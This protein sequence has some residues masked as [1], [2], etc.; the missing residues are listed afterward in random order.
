MKWFNN[1]YRPMPSPAIGFG[2]EPVDTSIPLIYGWAIH[3][4]LAEYYRSGF[5]DGFDTGI[6][7]I[8]Q[9]SKKLIAALES[10]RAENPDGVE[11]IFS[12]CEGLFVRYAE[13]DEVEKDVLRILSDSNGEPLIECEYEIELGYKNF[14]FTTRFDVIC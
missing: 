5:V 2:L 11:K 13:Y 6:R 3:E 1:Y 4:A 9:G 14:I 8:A 10:R 7:D 12:K